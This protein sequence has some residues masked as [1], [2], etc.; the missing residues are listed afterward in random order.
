MLLAEILYIAKDS[1]ITNFSFADCACKG[2]FRV[3]RGGAT[4]NVPSRCQSG[5]SASQRNPSSAANTIEPFMSVVVLEVET[6]LIIIGP[7]FEKMSG[8]FAK[9]YKVCSSARLRLLRAR[10]TLPTTKNRTTMLR[11]L[12]GHFHKSPASSWCKLSELKWYQLLRR[13]SSD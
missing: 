6:R 1:A 7:A 13:P 3:N 10:T 12:K 5:Q 9:L 4:L 2:Q 8:K 11:L